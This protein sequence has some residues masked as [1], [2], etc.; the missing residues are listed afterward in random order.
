MKRWIKWMKLAVG[1]KDDRMIND[2]GLPNKGQLG[3]V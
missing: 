1:F 3:R 2:H